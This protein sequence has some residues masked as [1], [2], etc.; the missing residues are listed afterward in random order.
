MRVRLAIRTVFRNRG[1][2]A[3][4]IAT[5]ALGIGANTTV[6][7]L[8]QAV[9]LRPLPFPQQE[10]IVTLWESDPADGI[11]HRAVTPA[12]FVDWA[13]QSDAFESIG[14]LPGV[15]TLL[16]KIVRPEGTERL[17][18]VYA[19]SGFFDALGM[20]AELGRLFGPEEDRRDGLRHVVIS[21]ALW[22]QRFHGD[23]DVIG[24]TINVDTWRGGEFTIVG[25]AQ[26][27]LEFPL[28]AD[29]WLSYGDSGVGPLPKPDSPERCCSWL[30]V[31]GR[32]KPGVT[33]SQA[34]AQMNVIAR[35]V[36]ERHP[37]ASNVGAVKV[38]ALREQMV[39][40]QRLAF[41]ALFGAVGC[42]LLIACANVANL[43]LSRGISREKEMLTRYAL[44][45]ST[46]Q[47]AQQLIAES[48]VLCS[49]GAAAGLLL[50]LWA[51][52]ALVGMLADRIPIIA[53]T[54]VDGSV[55]AFTALITVLSGIACGLAPLLHWRTGD[56]RS[57]AQTESSGRRLLR[58]AL[59]AGEIAL[60]LI[61]V[62][63]AGLLVRTVLKLSDVDF[64]FRTK[65]ILVVSTDVNTETLREPGDS[66]KFL[67]QLLPKL[68]TLP[69][70]TLAAAATALP[71]ETVWNI[72]P[73]TREDRAPRPQA[74]SPQVYQ[75]AVTPDYF[76]VLGIK[77]EKGRLFTGD[78]TRES[79]LVAVISETA[80]RRYWP[81][82][83]PIGRRFA[84]GSLEH[85]GWFRRPA[86][87]FGPEW[88]EV[89]GVVGDVRSSGYDSG[90]LPIAYYSHHQASVNSPFILV[91]T[92]DGAPSLAS[93]VR[94]EILTLNNRV[95]VTKSRG[96]DQVVADT[97]SEPRAR[98]GLVVSFA[99]LALLLGML[100]V[101]GVASYT[102]T[103]RTQEIGIRMALGAPR[104]EVARMV[105]GQALRLAIVGSALGLGASLVVAK[106]LSSLLFGI[107]PLDPLT[108]TVACLVLVGSAIAA[109]YFPAYR[110]MNI[111]PARALRNE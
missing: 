89:V 28:D 31:F 44:G 72:N 43:L 9:F 6:F 101:Y 39:A 54:R 56:L 76:S 70:A 30:A 2:A 10:R 45:A 18:G 93:A 17:R 49:L 106:A 42:V 79:K 86:D 38:T 95:V 82:E 36:S 107:Q 84:T 96:M 22:Q 58:S 14:V 60:S 21:H 108:L 37:E 66:A 62:A 7:S 12:N 67:D 99:A 23:P 16:F 64:G 34:E 92:A 81:G 19:S 11:D 3:L 103:L 29:I 102:V 88:R 73:I 20:T 61:L 27:G 98:A 80:A 85:F 25:V 59:V 68:R 97:I 46:W 77:L 50:S 65:Q 41:F 91:R 53:T 109:S 33:A 26:K 35:R 111:A 63:S 52:D 8:I 105:V 94:N 48:L 83:D 13:A 100:G 90:T 5:M 40:S 78:D 57:R 75:F 1:F 51:K 15:D 110:A 104:R 24:R 69:G 55:L 87:Q 47:I 4:I 32:L 71:V 74:E